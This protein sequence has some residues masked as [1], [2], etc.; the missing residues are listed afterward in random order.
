MKSTLPLF[1]FPACAALLLQAAA[2]DADFTAAVSKFLPPAK[3]AAAP[4]AATETTA[5]APAPVPVKSGEYTYSPDEPAAADTTP[6]A[7]PQEY[8]TFTQKL[9]EQAEKNAYDFCPAM[10][11]I[12]RTTNDEFA[13]ESWM[14]KAADEGYAAARQYMADVTLSNIP[15][16]KLVS[17]ETKAAYALVRKAA[18]AGYDPAKINV[19]ICLKNGIGVTKDEKGAERYLMEACKSGTPLPRFKWL[20]YSGRLEKFEDKGRP[21]VKAEI[22]RGNDHVVYYIGTLAEK[23]TDAFAWFKKAA[24][25]GNPEGMY[26][27]SALVS[28]QNGTR[29]SYELLAT[30]IKLH[31]A[32]AMLTLG[33]V[34]VESPED[35][36]VMTENNLKHDEKAGR[37][38]IKLAGMNGSYAA[39]FWLGRAYY[40]GRFGLP[41]D[42]ARAYRH[43]SHGAKL[44]NAACGLA[45]GLMLLRG[46]GV[47]KNEQEGLYHLNAAANAGRPDAVILLAYALYNGCGVPADAAKAAEILQEAAAMGATEAYVYLAYITAKGGTNL[48]ADARQAEKY[49]RMAQLDLDADGKAKVQSMYDELQHNGWD[50]KP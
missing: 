5:E 1:S 43:F 20:Q 38:L 42:A 23:G 45:K 50:P 3:A 46:L 30:A 15:A 34:L 28:K 21:E 4:T 32:E 10:E 44:G 49:L 40:E 22:D 18:D 31:H 41:Q 48:P 27:L 2:A 13:V 47:A 11:V 8:A 25:L 7:H 35:A 24:E 19:Y 36:A 37:H 26:T 14:K 6:A 16:D 33:S 29:Q 9:K 39:H 17:P 12:L